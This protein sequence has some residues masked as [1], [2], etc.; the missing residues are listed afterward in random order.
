[1]SIFEKASR[2]KLR[3][4]SLVGPISTEDLWDLPLTSKT[5]KANLDD[6]ARGVFRQLK[7]DDNVSFVN[8][9]QKSNETVQL[10]FDVV[11]HV[12]DIRIAE[13]DA[14]ALAASNKERKQ[15]ILSIIAQKENEQLLGTSMDDL[16][17]MLE[18]I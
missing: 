12:I 9:E 3:F 14:A 8:P 1:M 10:A 15:H 7:G 6:I 18:S 4:A 16:K 13:R 2:I 17:K 5:G 11:K